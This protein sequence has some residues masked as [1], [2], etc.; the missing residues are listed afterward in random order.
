M[1]SAGAPGGAATGMHGDNVTPQSFDPEAY[2]S[3]ISRAQEGEMASRRSKAMEAA[4]SKGFVSGEFSKSMFDKGI[5]TPTVD[6][7]GN[8]VDSTQMSVAQH[9]A[10]M[11]TNPSVLGD[12][13]SPFGQVVTGLGTT[14]F[15][16]LA[17]Q[18]TVATTAMKT[19]FTVMDMTTEIMRG[20][21]PVD[22]AL[23]QIP[24]AET[25]GLVD[26]K[27]VPGQTHDA[28][29]GLNFGQQV[30]H[31]I[32]NPFGDTSKGSKAYAQH[33]QNFGSVPQAV[34]GESPGEVSS[35]PSGVAPSIGPDSGVIERLRR[36]QPKSPEPQK[37]ADTE[38]L[39]PVV[40]AEDL[41]RRRLI[42]TLG[43][44]AASP[45]QLTS[46]LGSA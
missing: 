21:D 40:S 9:K 17:P 16:L 4:T 22:V 41:R 10:H 20:E 31:D 11:A 13:E 33:V 43:G 18:M 2:G 42:A 19:A 25:I 12:P 24:F 23:G 8:V 5:A 37:L 44:G 34:G 27:T 30:M 45:L 15:S 6:S 36:A 39:G 35:A 46:L 28:K 14:A 38:P 29:E 1:G 3:K 7:F 26:K 32:R